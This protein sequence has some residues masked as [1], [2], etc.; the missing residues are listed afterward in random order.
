MKHTVVYALLALFLSTSCSFTPMP[1]EPNPLWQAGNASGLYNT[2]TGCRIV[3]GVDDCT[4]PY[5][6]VEAYLAPLFPA[7]PN[8]LIPSLQAIGFRCDLETRH[9][10]WYCH[11]SESRAPQA[12]AVAERVTVGL[13]FKSNLTRITQ[14]DVTLVT[15]S[16]RDPANQDMRGCSPH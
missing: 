11:Y 9:A 10:R 1:P 13:S 5:E 16:V 3:D 15:T 2:K 4:T 6:R 7:T 14:R 12:C 8:A